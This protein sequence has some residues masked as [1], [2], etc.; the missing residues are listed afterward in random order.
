MTEV[1]NSFHGLTDRD[2]DLLRMRYAEGK[3][4]PEIAAMF[5]VKEATVYS[6][7]FR[8]RKH[9]EE[10]LDKGGKGHDE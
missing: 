5:G 7:L 3:T 8:A 1:L 4:V 2:Q 6:A 9:L 10:I